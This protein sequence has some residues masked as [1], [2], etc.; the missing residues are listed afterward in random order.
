MSKSLGNIYTLRDLLAMGFDP[1]AIRWT[2]IATH[3]RQPSNFTFDALAAS[4]EAL[5][6]VRDFRIRLGEVRGQGDGLAAVAERCEREFGD[7]LDDDLN[8]SGAIAAVFDFIREGNRLLDKNQA[9]AEGAKQALAVLERLDAVTGLLAGGRESAPQSVLDLVQERQS[10]RRNKDF[11]RAD[12]L[13]DELLA[14]GWIIEDTP[15]GP[16]VKRI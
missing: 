2:L 7:A 15:D 5:R 8:I 12:A 14:Q 6:R 3:Y 1:A 10:A 9:G 16:R 13:R 4:A 11:R